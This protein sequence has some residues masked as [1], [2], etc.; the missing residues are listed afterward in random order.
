MALNTF[1]RDQ[2]YNI[3]NLVKIKDIF[4][5]IYSWKNTFKQMGNLCN[6][7]SKEQT[8]MIAPNLGRKSSTDRNSG[9]VGQ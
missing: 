7:P 1:D 8:E 6:P 4:T 5:I 9:S 2:H 3:H